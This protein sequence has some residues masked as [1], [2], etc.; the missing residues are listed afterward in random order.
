MRIWTKT[1]GL[2]FCALLAVYNGPAAFSAGETQAGSAD[3]ASK[4]KV[5]GDAADPAA[6]DAPSPTRVVASDSGTFSIQ[7]SNDDSLIHVLRLIGD[8]AQ[9]S[10]IPSREVRGTVPAMDLNNVTLSEA[11]DAILQSNGMAWQQKGNLIFVYT[12]KE[13]A[14]REKAARKAATK[15]F[16]LH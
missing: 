1:T 9:R 4:V 2:I 6:P 15:T 3:S 5:I 14:D 12:Q 13:L 11:L 16:T 8:E 10:I 7:I